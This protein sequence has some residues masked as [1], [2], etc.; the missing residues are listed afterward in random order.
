[1]AKT[2]AKN[3]T[4]PAAEAIDPAAMATSTPPPKPEAQPA[5]QPEPELQPESVQE[6]E[7]AEE[8][9]PV[10]LERLG[11]VAD[12]AALRVHNGYCAKDL[13]CYMT[14]RQAAAA[15]MGMELL[16]ERAERF[17]GG[18]STHPDGTVVDG[19]NDFVRWLLDRVADEFEDVTGKSLLHD[20]DLQF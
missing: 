18:R 16:R 10:H 20:F 6:I 17:E 11:I 8:T 13:H 3:N 7:P 1:M 2:K 12:R 19:R 14:A 4:Q 15:K 9:G 5:P